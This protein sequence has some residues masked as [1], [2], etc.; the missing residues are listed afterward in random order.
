[1]EGK[2][3]VKKVTIVLFFSG[4]LFS[5]FLYFFSGIIANLLNNKE[6]EV[7]LQTF[8]IIPTL[9]LPTLGIEGIF[10]TYKKT[11]YV[12]IYNT[13]TRLLTLL[14][15]VLPVILF[16]GSYLTALYG[17]IVVSF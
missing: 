12:A 17:W 8:A 14:F 4:L 16:N 13:F 15:I 6:L 3:I 7:G 11:I 9:L 5:S 2:N 10:S 1:S